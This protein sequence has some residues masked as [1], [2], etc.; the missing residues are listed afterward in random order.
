MNLVILA[1]GL[2]SRFGGLKQ[3]EPIDN[4]NNFFIDYSVYDAIKCGFEKIVF[5]VK[6]ENFEI[7]QETVG[8][9]L[10]DKIKVEFVFQKSNNIP[11]EILKKER[12]KPWGTGHAILCCKEKVKENFAMINA[13]DFYG[14]DAFEKAFSLLQ[15]L[16]E[17]NFGLVGYSA[18]KT[19]SENGETK[20]GVCKIENNHLL[21]IE[22]NSLYLENGQI[23]AKK[24]NGE[25]LRTISP[26]TTVSMNM[27]CFTPQIF[28][29]LQEKFAEFLNDNIDNLETCEFLIPEVLQSAI[30][31]NK[32]TVAVVHTNSNW[33]G[34]TY[35]EDKCKVMQSVE[36]LK[37]EG[38]Y[39]N[40]LWNS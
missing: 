12:K 3:V 16:K 10:Q 14:R 27:L 22:E 37:K 4:H 38:V 26:D 20:R 5:V 23:F 9:R 35:A 17:M 13:D 6:E 32:A 24:L 8:K 34:M 29:Y 31:E 28:E 19:L 7:F 2:G 39:P 33:F 25:N 21:T 36:D 11:T 30:D 15:N 40:N 18:G 1:A